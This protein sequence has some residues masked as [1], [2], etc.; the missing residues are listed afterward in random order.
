MLPRVVIISEVAG[1][2]KF[3]ILSHVYETIK[4]K[5]SRPVGYHNQIIQNNFELKSHSVTEFT[6]INFLV[7][8]SIVD[9]YP[10]N[11]PFTVKT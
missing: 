2:G 9:D 11:C 4:E 1:T 10:F 5:K 8:L 3:N 6:A 7:N